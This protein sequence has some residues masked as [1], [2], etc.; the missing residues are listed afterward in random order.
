VRDAEFDFGEG[1]R[2]KDEGTSRA[3]G[4]AS[5]VEFNH[6][7]Q[8]FFFGLKTGDTFT[9]D[10]LTKFAGLPGDGS[11]NSANAVGAWILGMQKAKFIEWTGGHEQSSRPER[12]AALNK[13]W[14][15]IRG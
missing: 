4:N 1:L 9:L 3:R 13:I 14:R 8:Q 11:P 15:K 12:H 2:R 5:N 10:D 7:A 6:N